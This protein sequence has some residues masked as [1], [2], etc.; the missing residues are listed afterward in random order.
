[1][2]RY[3]GLKFPINATEVNPI[4][5]GNKITHVKESII[6]NRTFQLGWGSYMFCTINDGLFTNPIVIVPKTA[7][8][9]SPSGE[10]EQIVTRGVYTCTAAAIQRGNLIC[11]LHLDASDIET[12]GNEI[13]TRIIATLNNGNGDISIIASRIASNSEQ[14][15]IQSLYEQCHSIA[16]VHSLVINRGN[17]ITNALYMPSANPAATEIP[18]EKRFFGHLEFGI[19]IGSNGPLVFGDLVSQVPRSYRIKQ[20]SLEFSDNQERVNYI[21][22]NATQGD[23]AEGS[24]EKLT[25]L[26]L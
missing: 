8:N 5:N 15:F 7:H 16:T 10:F 18:A 20:F 3:E 12:K 19:C 23:Q 22:D 2:T 9:D 14:R 13:I 26:Y 24:P 4:L 11:L 21:L 6:Y 17:N 1:M 25:I